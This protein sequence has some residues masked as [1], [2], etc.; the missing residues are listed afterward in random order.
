[1]TLGR[2]KSYDDADLG[3]TNAELRRQTAV[4]QFAL[5]KMRGNPALKDQHHHPADR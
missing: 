3:R 2:N 4:C 1:L 5:R